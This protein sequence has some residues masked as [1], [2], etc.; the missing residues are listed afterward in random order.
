M[1][2][3]IRLAQT[4]DTEDK[5]RKKRAIWK[6]EGEETKPI[7]SPGKHEG[8]EEGPGPP[9]SDDEVSQ[10]GMPTEKTLER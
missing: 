1:F 6:R 3:S 8:Q 5:S 4:D 9:D 10:Q 2:S 7:H